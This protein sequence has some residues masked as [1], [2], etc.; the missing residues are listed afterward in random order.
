M[1]SKFILPYRCSL[2]LSVNLGLVEYLFF[3][4]NKKQDC[5]SFAEF[6]ENLIIKGLEIEVFET[7]DPELPNNLSKE[8]QIEWYSNTSF[9][10]VAHFVGKETQKLICKNRS[11]SH[12]SFPD[13]EKAGFKRVL[14]FV[15]IYLFLKDSC[16]ISF[17]QFKTE[18]NDLLFECLCRDPY[19]NLFYLYLTNNRWELKENKTSDLAHIKDESFRQLLLEKDK[20]PM[21]NYGFYQHFKDPIKFNEL[22]KQHNCLID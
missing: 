6:L 11:S 1:I 8:E 10:L 18:P 20:N 13:V 22:L 17:S 4:Y 7:T 5:A 14:E 16:N 15:S 12:F 19:G 21:E 2:S 3:E 9:D